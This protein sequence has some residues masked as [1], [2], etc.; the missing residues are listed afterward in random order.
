MFSLLH[1]LSCPA[2]LFQPVIHLRAVL[3]RSTFLDHLLNNA[4]KCANAIPSLAMACQSI[5]TG[6]CVA[7]QAW[8]WLGPGMDFG[9]SF[10][11]VTSHKTLAAV[12]ASK[13]SIA[14]VGLDMRLDVFFPAE[15]LVAVVIF[16]HPFVVNGVWPFDE[17]GNVIQGDIC[18]FDGSAHTR[19]QFK[20]GNREPSGGV[21]GLGRR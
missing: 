9:V 2:R 8:V 10:E 11:I 18:L 16:A 1:P 17:L 12:V 13:L 20:V 21:L 3:P 4:L 14:E 19:F 6:K 7:A 5:M 15:F